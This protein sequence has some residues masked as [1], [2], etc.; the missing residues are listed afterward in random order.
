MWSFTIC[1]CCLECV[2][3]RG[4]GG[5]RRPVEIGRQRGG[6]RRD[7]AVV[8]QTRR[9]SWGSVIG[10]ERQGSEWS[11]VWRRPKSAGADVGW[12]GAVAV[13]TPKGDW[14]DARYFWWCSKDSNIGTG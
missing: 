5:E 8:S 2:W 7:C 3:G 13:K 10:P 1:A 12:D 4:K 9:P 11:A 6:A 14:V